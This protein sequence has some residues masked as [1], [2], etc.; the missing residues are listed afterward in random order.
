MDWLWL[1]LVGLLVGALGRLIS[2]GRDP[3]GWV[4]TLLL[5]VGSLIVAG[6]IFGTDGF[7]QFVFGVIIAVIL[8]AIYGRTVGKR[9]A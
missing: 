3:M 7:W 6:L 4:I 9:T 1:I 5:G 8:V 2:P